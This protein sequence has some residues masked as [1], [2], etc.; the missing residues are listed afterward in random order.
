MGPLESHAAGAVPST[1][2]KHFHF[3]KDDPRGDSDHYHLYCYYRTSG[4]EWSKGKFHTEWS[5]ADTE[6][7]TTPDPK[8]LAQERYRCECRALREADR[9][10]VAPRERLSARA[11]WY[12]YQEPA[13]P[14]IP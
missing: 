2:R 9:G 4:P 8:A 13:M 11:R 3:K 1:L 12:A 5:I 7:A 6:N 14:H 10:G